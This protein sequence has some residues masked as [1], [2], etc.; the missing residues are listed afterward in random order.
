MRDRI[1]GTLCACLAAAS[2]SAQVPAGAPF[3]VNTYTTSDQQ[4]PRFSTLPNGDSVAVWTSRQQDNSIFG[5]F[6]Q[7]Y[8]PDGTPRGGEFRVDTGNFAGLSAVA[9][10][11]NTGRF[12]VVWHDGTGVSNFDIHGRRFSAN[13][14]TRGAEFMVNTSTTGNGYRPDIAP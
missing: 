3:R 2:V 9:Q 6:G 11:D 13:G 12:M 8:Q 14:A 1:V 7:R 5:L 10:S 4:S